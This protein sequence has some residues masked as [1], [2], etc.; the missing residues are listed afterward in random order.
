MMLTF[1][2]YLMDHGTLAI[3]NTLH[4]LISIL[5]YISYLWYIIWIN[6]RPQFWT[7]FLFLAGK[8]LFLASSS[9][10]SKRTTC[11]YHSLATPSMCEWPWGT[12]GVAA[13]QSGLVALIPVR[14]GNRGYPQIICG[15]P[16]PV[17]T[18]TTEQTQQ[19]RITT[20]CILNKKYGKYYASIS[21]L[22]AKHV[23]RFAF[24]YGGEYKIL[25]HCDAF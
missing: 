20:R 19:N 3:L 21:Q 2:F 9:D 8:C 4:V 10:A 1:P 6:F 5:N 25:L 13:P 16:S 17:P 24:C 23:G 7:S 18:D 15:S 14:L 22:T 12:W 11:P